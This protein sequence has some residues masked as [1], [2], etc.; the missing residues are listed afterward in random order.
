MKKFAE[1]IE[2]L[3]SGSKTNVKLEALNQ[4]FLSAADEDKIWVIALFTGRRPKRAVST[5]LLRQWCIELAD[6][7]AWL[8]EESYHTVG[9]LAEAIALLIPKQKNAMLLEHSLSY[10]VNK[11]GALT[12]EPDDIKKILCC[13]HGIP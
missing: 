1:L 13:M 11:L 2:L 3:S 10:Y 9:D 4:Y 12:K 7:P 8:F 6:I 5:S